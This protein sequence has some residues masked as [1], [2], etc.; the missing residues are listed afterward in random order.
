MG[1]HC[2]KLIRYFGFDSNFCWIFMITPLC[3]VII[4]IN[5]FV[6]IFLPNNNQWNCDTC[7]IKVK[8][9]DLL[10]LKLA[11]FLTHRFQILA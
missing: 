4:T 1:G 3:F 6:F 10:V 8:E 2:C 11:G 7:N 9:P 5:S